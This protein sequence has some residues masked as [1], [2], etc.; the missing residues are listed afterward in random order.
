MHRNQTK[1]E[2]MNKVS[3]RCKEEKY[4]KFYYASQKMSFEAK[5]IKLLAFVV[6]LVPIILSLITKVNS[7]VVFVATMF[8]FSLTLILEFTASFITNHKEKSILLGQCYQAGITGTTFAKVEYDREMTNELS[9]LAIRKSA[10]SM[11][12]L[13]KY[14]EV[15]VP[16]DVEDKFGYLYLARLNAAKTNYL[17]SRMYGFYIFALIVIIVAFVSFAFIKNDSREFLQLI[18]QFYPL[19]MPV[20]RN[21]SASQK[22]KRKCAKI[23][24]DIDNYFAAGDSSNEARAKMT[25]Y[26]QN[27]EFEALMASPAQYK[28]FIKLYSRGL[29]ILE[30]GVASRFIE[31]E[32]SLIKKNKKK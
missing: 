7:T 19:V 23:S 8:S 30:K 21:I 20:I 25:W 10:T 1:E 4:A 29:R 5:L 27:L 16:E 31:A 9:E 2:Q 3:K 17:M 12:G 15:A 13:K 14:N 28:I 6:S 32:N 18:I 22:T 24:A 11:A 26:A